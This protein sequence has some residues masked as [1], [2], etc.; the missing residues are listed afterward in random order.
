MHNDTEASGTQ[1]LGPEPEKQGLF[2][3]IK[4][5]TAKVWRQGGGGLLRVPA[6]SPGPFCTW[7]WVSQATEQPRPA[8]VSPA[9]VTLLRQLPGSAGP[10]S[11]SQTLHCDFW[12]AKHFCLRGCLP[13]FKNLL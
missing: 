3:F 13:R 6:F 9:S 4:W 7:A 10:L 2:A 5:A 12:G 1:A 11:H 8:W